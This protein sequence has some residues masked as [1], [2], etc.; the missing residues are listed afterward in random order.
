M[1]HASLDGLTLHVRDVERSREFYSRIPG[2]ELIAHRPGEFCLFRIG[3]GMLG[4]L[5]WRQT[6]FH[7]EVGVAD[8]EGTYGALRAVG[9]EPAGPPRDRPWGERTFDVVDPDGN[10]L[11]FQEA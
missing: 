6:G 11:E 1:T 5:Q 8:L 4:L 7:L 9:V 2:T 10:Q 3:A